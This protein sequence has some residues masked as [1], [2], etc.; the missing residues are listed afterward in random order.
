MTIELKKLRY[1]KKNIIN[2][3]V[4]AKFYSTTLKKYNIQHDISDKLDLEQ[5]Y[6]N[7][8]L[9]LTGNYKNPVN[10]SGI[11]KRNL[12]NIDTKVEDEPLGNVDILQDYAQQITEEVI[13]ISTRSTEI[14]TN[15]FVNENSN[16]FIYNEGEE[17]LIINCNITIFKQILNKQYDSIHFT[18]KIPFEFV[19]NNEVYSDYIQKTQPIEINKT[20]TLT[21]IENLPYKLL[22]NTRILLLPDINVNKTILKIS[23]NDNDNIVKMYHNLYSVNKLQN[24]TNLPFKKLKTYKELNFF[25]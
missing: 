14:L 20:Y 24:I 11:C 10:K 9:L 5:M 23:D 25:K 22:L 8:D 13:S 18:N 2:F 15:K 7:I 19:I 3:L 1:I 16:S 21:K 12:T 17:I 4:D 6:N